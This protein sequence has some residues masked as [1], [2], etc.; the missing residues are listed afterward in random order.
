MSPVFGHPIN[1]CSNSMIYFLSTRW[2]FQTHCNFIFIGLIWP[3]GPLCFSYFFLLFSSSLSLVIH[4]TFLLIF[5]YLVDVFSSRTI[6]HIEK[7]LSSSFLEL[8]WSVF[9]ELKMILLSTF[10]QSIFICWFLDS[11]QANSDFLI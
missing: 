2:H 8:K 5:T 9:R 7:F 1:K 3:Y 4:P 6:L 11:F 10:L